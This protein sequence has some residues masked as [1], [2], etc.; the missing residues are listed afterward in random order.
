VELDVQNTNTV[1]FTGTAESI[2]T[3]KFVLAVLRVIAI[4]ANPLNLPGQSQNIRELL[5][6]YPSD[7]K[8]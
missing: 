8:W 6:Q 7:T 2:Y 3:V 1:I 5:G 4:V